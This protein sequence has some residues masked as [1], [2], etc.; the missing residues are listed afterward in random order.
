[1]LLQ[2]RNTNVWYYRYGIILTGNKVHQIQK[3]AHQAVQ[4]LGM[5]QGY[6]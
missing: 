1:M 5:E 4:V 6:K 3:A 2:N